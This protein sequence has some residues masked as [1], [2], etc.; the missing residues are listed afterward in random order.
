MREAADET[1]ILPVREV[2]VDGGEL[3]C[4][5]DA[6]AHPLRFVGDVEAQHGRLAG[7]GAEDRRQH[8]HGSGLAGAVGAEQ[9]EHGCGRD[10][11]V[12]AVERDDVAEA[13]LQTL[14]CDG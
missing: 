6:G 3:A 12:D 11:E 13:L 10:L 9:A 14:D 4:E 7:V 2:A 5:T 1:Q 8:P